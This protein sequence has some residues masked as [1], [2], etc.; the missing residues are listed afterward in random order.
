MI[1]SSPLPDLHNISNIE[2]KVL[3]LIRPSCFFSANIFWSFSAWRCLSICYT[4]MLGSFSWP[5]PTKKQPLWLWKQEK[6]QTLPKA[7]RTRG[8][9]SAY[10]SKVYLK[11]LNKSNFVFR[12]ST[13]LQLQNFNQTSAFGLSM[14]FRILTKHSFWISTEIKLYNLNQASAAKYWPNFSFKFSPE[15]QPKNHDQTLCSKPEQ[16]SNF[17]TKP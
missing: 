4:H 16:E 17:M 3:S 7:Q 12:I 13:K 9:S 5:L 8:L 10:Q 6:V 1:F 15:L 11:L 2:R 14:N